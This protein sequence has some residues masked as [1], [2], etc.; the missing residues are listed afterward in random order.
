MFREKA[1]EKLRSPEQLDEP[2]LTIRRFDRL[3][4]RTSGYL[5][6]FFCIWG[7][8]GRIP[9]PGTGQGILI[10]PNTIVPIQAPSEGQIMTWHVKV[11][12]VVNRGDVIAVLG[13][14]DTERNIE[15]AEAR[16]REVRHRNSELTSMR[17][18][19]VQAQLNSLERKRSNIGARI[20]YLQSFIAETRAVV[21]EMNVNNKILLEMRRSN[22]SEARV[23]AA[24]LSEAWLER[25]EAY[26]RLRAE[27]LISEESVIQVQN[28]YDDSLIN[29]RSLDLQ[30]KQTDLAAVELQEAYALAK[31][32]ISGKQNLL[33]DLELQLGE[34]DKVEAS[35]NKLEQ[36]AALRDLNEVSNLERELAVAERK[37][38]EELMV[39]A[40]QD[41][42]ILELTAA[43]GSVVSIG[44]RVAQLDTRLDDDDLLVLAYFT[45]KVG[46]ALHPGMA[47][48][49]AP[50]TVP[51][52]QFGTIVG[53][54]VS[55]TDF[56]VT[57]EAVSSYV[58]NS[59]VA[60]RLTSRG[61]EIQATI[62]MNT[63]PTTA[64]G[65]EWTS[66]LGP[67]LL[68]TAGTTAS[69]Q[70]TLERRAPFSYIMPVL[71]E[72]SGL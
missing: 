22:L 72:W 2:V 41:G 51:Q 53:T 54:L 49:V 68:I 1:L 11:G 46:K 48:R 25:Q 3:A 52:R 43:E 62:S 64:T 13:Q 8:F 19:N 44:Q 27:N 36:E 70:V 42:R 31:N 59:A 29:L 18:I 37:L 38:A 20:Q 63:S 21:D 39:R 14:P 35:I 17:E 69:V 55:V 28:N 9:E 26:R 34:L 40:D 61:R 4:V 24:E 15:V 12:D 10:T 32:Q 58:G 47:V 5:F 65:Y 67:E 30:I 45:P 23:A 6:L 71:R 60:Q 50:D 56:P 33:A 66:E 16:L 57:T 7:V